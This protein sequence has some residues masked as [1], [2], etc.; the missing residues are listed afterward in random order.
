M[1]IEEFKAWFDGYVEAGGKD[2][3][4][5]KEKLNEVVTLAPIPI[6][7]PWIIPLPNVYPWITTTGESVP[8]DTKIQ[9][10]C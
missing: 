7:N 10:I 2:I 3:Q 5:V 9:W 8:L 1:T 6:P 4:R